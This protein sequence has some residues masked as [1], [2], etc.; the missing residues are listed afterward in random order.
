MPNETRQGT[1]NGTT[2]LAPKGSAALGFELTNLDEALKWAGV[3]AKSGL[4]PEPLRNKPDD[5]LVVLLKGHELGLKPMQALSS[6]A[7]VKGKA[8]MEAQLKVSLC[9][10][11][12]EVC[13]YFRL[14]ESTDQKATYETL[15]QGDPA[16]T[17]LSY[18]IE[19]AAKAALTQKDNWKGYAAAMLRARCSSHLATAVYPDL[20][21]GIYDPD[22]AEEL[23][24]GP[25][26]LN[27]PTA[28]P[29][30][31]KLEPQDAEVVDSAAEA[32]KTIEEWKAKI[33]GA[34]T[35]ADLEALVPGLRQLPEALRKEHLV[36][37]YNA[38]KAAL[39]PQGH[40]QQTQGA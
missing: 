14:V 26:D 22:E 37:V 8:V 31:T 13:T 11:H 40:A 10:R 9:L 39:A 34:A 15:R 27:K 30:A 28:P 29:V 23:E 38:K 12:K 7:V 21:G 36:P 16:P 32:S 4:L 33:E 1:Q 20:V 25:Y 17:T 6:M 24:R 35:A 2:A 5:V 18:T 19:Q 3:L